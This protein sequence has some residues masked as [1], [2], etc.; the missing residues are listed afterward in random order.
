[1]TDRRLQLLIISRMRINCFSITTIN[2][3]KAQIT[4]KTIS[5]PKLQGVQE[6]FTWTPC[7]EYLSSIDTHLKLDSIA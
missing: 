7:I 6:R 4:S 1:M 5:M 2:I 3:K